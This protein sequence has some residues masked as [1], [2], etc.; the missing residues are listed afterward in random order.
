M[1]TW[2]SWGAHTRTYISCVPSELKF[3]KKINKQ[4]KELKF[5]FP[6]FQDLPVLQEGYPDPNSSLTFFILASPAWPT[7]CTVP[8]TGLV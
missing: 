2:P 4:K 1:Q 7:A 8:L 3:K 6:V 5:K